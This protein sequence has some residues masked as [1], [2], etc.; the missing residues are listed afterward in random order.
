MN[1]AIVGCGII[2]FTHAKAIAQLKGETLYAVCDIIPEKADAF[3]KE[4]GAQR[5]YYDHRSLLADEN[6]DI[7]CVCV[8]SGTHAEICIDAAKAGKAIVCEK[9]LE[10]TPGRMRR[11]L[12]AVN[13]A[14]VK[15]Q[16]IFQRRL[17]PT[18]I[19]VRQM[20]REGKL[21]RI[22]MA[23]ASLLYYRDQ[24]YYDSAGWRGTLEQDGGG[25][26]MNQGV[27]GVD[28]MLWM[29]GGRIASLY[30]AAATLGRR[31]EVE[32]TAAAIL[33]MEEGTLLL[34]KSA[35]AT[36]PGFST[37][38]SVYGEKGTVSFSD[39]GI[40][41]WDFLDPD[42]APMRPD[43]DGSDVVGGARDPRQIG[44]Y[45]HICLLEDIANAVR[46]DRQPMIPPEDAM[47][48]VDV[49]CAIYASSKKRGEVPV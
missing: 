42:T 21:G 46:E 36:Y 38:M 9:P 19:A 23:E 6:V 18:A 48:A 11:V 32:D 17:M 3:Q 5:V 8:P 14:G 13:G 35:T 47:T 34:I 44:I 41:L 39:D 2:A 30:G 29:L 45:G 12:E 16:C 40:L 4:H 43:Q 31:I 26:L 27:H 37:T 22:Y 1:F 24:A 33:R 25:C 28:L 7:V 20:I 49:I 15:M 10:I